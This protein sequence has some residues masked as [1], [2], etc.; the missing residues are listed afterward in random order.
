MTR[1]QSVR[2]PVPT[3]GSWIATILGPLLFFAHATYLSDL[4]K[5]WI[6]GTI[7]EGQWMRF[8]ERLQKEWD[9]DLIIVRFWQN[10]F[11]LSPFLS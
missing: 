10:I 2:G 11:L 6:D 1:D 4:E 7:K 9:K 3:G 8:V 5:M